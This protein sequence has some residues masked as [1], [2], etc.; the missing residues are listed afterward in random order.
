MKD[1][2]H[3]ISHAGK[4]YLIK[5]YQYPHGEHVQLHMYLYLPPTHAVAPES[6]R[7]GADMD[8]WEPARNLDSRLLEDFRASGM[9]MRCSSRCAY[10][11]TECLHSPSAWPTTMAA[12]VSNY[13]CGSGERLLYVMDRDPNQL[14][15]TFQ[16]STS[17]RAELDRS[18]YGDMHVWRDCASCSITCGTE[19][20]KQ[21]HGRKHNRRCL[22]CSLGRG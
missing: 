4:M 17:E 6:L 8:T 7:V 2:H 18:S 20:E 1:E 11:P 16:M 9:H 15:K 19:K 14:D 10:E 5:W 13:I 22:A 21:K 3:L 12:C